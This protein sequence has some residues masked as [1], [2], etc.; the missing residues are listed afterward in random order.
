MSDS[1]PDYPAFRR[2]L[3]DIL[4]QRNPEALRAFLIAEGQWAEATATDPESAM[5]M[6]IATSPTLASQRDEARQ[7]LLTHGHEAEAQA[8]FG[9]QRTRG[10]SPNGRGYPN[11]RGKAGQPASQQANTG[12]PGKPSSRPGHRD[13]R[14]P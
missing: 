2:R 13:H 6:M 12:K 14:C 10:T 4:R 11:R 3:D 7:W 5:W 8:I 9:A 1:P